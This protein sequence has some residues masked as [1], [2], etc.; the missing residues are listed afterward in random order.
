MTECFRSLPLQ[1][2]SDLPEAFRTTRVSDSEGLDSAADTIRY[3]DSPRQKKLQKKLSVA[4]A[5]NSLL[6][7]SW[8][9]VGKPQSQLQAS[10]ADTESVQ[11]LSDT[12]TQAW[13]EE[14]AGDE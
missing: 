4:E 1:D 3:D 10:K 2:P 8:N 12:E 6:S 11:S 9:V 13:G 14:E 5:A 7:D